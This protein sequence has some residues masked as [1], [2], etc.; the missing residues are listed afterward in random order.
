[1]QNLQIR[2]DFVHSSSLQTLQDAAVLGLVGDQ[3]ILPGKP[4]HIRSI[5]L[6]NF[7]EQKLE[8]PRELVE[9][10]LCPGTEWLSAKPCFT[11][12]FSSAQ[13]HFFMFSLLALGSAGS[14]VAQCLVRLGLQK[15][16]PRLQR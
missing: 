7:E 12:S 13:G 14:G 6:C 5:T 9:S 4:N 1:M 8:C 10:Y 2:A 15:H 3:F 16:E 11:I